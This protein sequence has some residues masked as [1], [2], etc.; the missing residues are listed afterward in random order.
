MQPEA[1]DTVLADA[2]RIVM[3]GAS[4]LTLAWPRIVDLL[5]SSFADPVEIYTAHG[6]GRSYCGVRSGFG[7]RQLPG[8]LRS[9]LWNALPL[10]NKDSP[11]PAALITD[12]GNDLVYGRS[13]QQVADAA[14]E[15]I[16][17]LRSWN[18]SCGI[19]M[20]R[21]PIDSL[22]GLGSLRFFIC[23]TALFPFSGLKLKAIQ[24]A[25]G[26]LD[27]RIVDIANQFSVA[28]SRPDPS[29]YGL[30]PI[31]VKWN[32]QTLAFSKIMDLWELKKT[33]AEQPGGSLNSRPTAQTRWVFGREKRTPQ[34]VLTEDKTS[35]FAY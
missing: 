5:R 23:K 8:I 6:M 9:E 15:S 32:H 34:P 24:A 21:P 19:V 2:N 28:L 4:N 10:H 30:D 3:L 16:K 7:I 13:P 33:G 35:V 31:H 25:A 18:S 14:V 20:T 22:N 29:W 11:Q 1:F 17:R 27:K 26:E 12:L